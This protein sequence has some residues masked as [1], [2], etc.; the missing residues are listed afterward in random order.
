M[1]W[2]A[3][4]LAQPARLFGRCWKD[5]WTSNSDGRYTPERNYPHN[6][7]ELDA[8]VAEWL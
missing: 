8:H 7:H 5:Y 2:P 1:S 6:S 3:A 4:L